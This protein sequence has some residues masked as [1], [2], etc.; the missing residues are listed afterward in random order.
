MSVS[1]TRGRIRGAGVG[2]PERRVGAG[3]TNQL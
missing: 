2:S 3:V 1:V